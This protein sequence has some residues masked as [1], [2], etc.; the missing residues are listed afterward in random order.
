MT[1]ASRQFVIVNMLET[2]GPMNLRQLGAKLGWDHSTIG[3][4]LA[5]L[6]KAGVVKRARVARFTGPKKPA[7]EWR[8]A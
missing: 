6:H 4:D 5:A 8:I 7:F 3:L 2:E 1:P